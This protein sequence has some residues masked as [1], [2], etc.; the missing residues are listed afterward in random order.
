MSNVVG[1]GGRAHQT[2]AEVRRQLAPLLVL[3]VVI[4]A[5]IGVAALRERA[6]DGRR[7]ELLLVRLDGLTQEQYALVG[8]A[9]AEREA[10]DEL[11]ADVRA[12]RAA[13]DAA[14]GALAVLGESPA[15]SKDLAGLEARVAAFRD[16]SDDALRMLAGGQPALAAAHVQSPDGA[17]GAVRALLDQLHAA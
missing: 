9:V 17:G 8:R 2:S 6:D 15:T 10:D 5:V 16:A 13:F 11:L 14:L 1:D 4:G 12:S 7:A 3:L